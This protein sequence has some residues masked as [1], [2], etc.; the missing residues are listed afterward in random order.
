MSGWGPTEPIPAAQPLALPPQLTPIPGKTTTVSAGGEGT[1][2]G[3]ASKG[4]RKAPSRHIGPHRK[5]WPLCS[6]KCVLEGTSAED[7]GD[8]HPPGS[9]LRGDSSCLWHLARAGWGETVAS[10]VAYVQGPAEQGLGGDHHF[11]GPSPQPL[12]SCALKS[13]T[14]L[15]PYGCPRKA[16]DREAR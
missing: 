10:S 8:C 9:C 3:P 16:H 13:P 7:N 14:H 12:G 2:G 4:C 11:E 5:S 15:V 6:R 1:W